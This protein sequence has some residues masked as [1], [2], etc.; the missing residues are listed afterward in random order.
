MQKIVHD[1]EQDKEPVIS[2]PTWSMPAYTGS[3]RTSTYLREQ[4]LREAAKN[5]QKITTFFKPKPRAHPL[6]SSSTP[7][8]I[9]STPESP[10]NPV[11]L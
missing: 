10:S 3:G 4:Q 1:M 5:N 11:A 9:N 6:P 2:L 7:E 8:L